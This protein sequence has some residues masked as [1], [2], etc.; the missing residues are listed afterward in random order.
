MNRIWKALALLCLLC[1]LLPAVFAAAD[2][3]AAQRGLEAIKTTAHWDYIQLPKP[4]SYL[5]EWKTLYGRRAWY[6]PSLFV[7]SVPML[8]SGAPIRPY[9]FEGTQVTVVAEENDMSCIL[10]RGW[11]NRLY[12]G[13]IQSIRLL[14]EFPGI[15]LCVG[16][17]RDGTAAIETDARLTF[18]GSWFPGT[19]QPYSLL[20]APAEDCVGFTLEYQ[21]IAENTY[22]KWMVFGP[23]TIYVRDGENWVDVGSFPY[24]ELG[25]VHVQVWL[26]EPMDVTAVATVA[27]CHAPNIF[28]FRQ[29]AW[30][31]LRDGD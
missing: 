27:D 13:W 29:N 9:L 8:K 26:P 14:D 10:Y 4:E 16:E 3:T 24:P 17:A 28:D 2:E 30:G 22:L 21:I 1:L 6:A 15:E 7:E 25:T 12:S 5:E 31:F 18:A 20:T 19:E 23:R 11:D